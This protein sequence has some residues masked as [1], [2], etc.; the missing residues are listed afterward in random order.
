MEDHMLILDFSA[1]EA[2]A[3]ANLMMFGLA[4]AA[5]NY[6]GEESSLVLFKSVYEKVLAATEGMWE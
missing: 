5:K 4:V 1:E 2:V 3:F 6:D